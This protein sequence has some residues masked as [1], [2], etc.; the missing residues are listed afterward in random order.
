MPP[1]PFCHVCRSQEVVWA[2]LPGGGV[3]YTFTVVRHAVI[4]E[5]RG[6]VPYVVA[7]VDLDGAP[8]ARL[9]GNVVDVDPVVV[10]IDMQVQVVWDDVAEDVTIPRFRPRAVSGR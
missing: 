8:G 2:E 5:A 6:A 7:V 4:P 3:I 9:I 1:S 10:T